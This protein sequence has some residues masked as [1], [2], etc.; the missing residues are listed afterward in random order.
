MPRFLPLFDAAQARALDR[1]A[2]AALGITEYDLMQRAA[3]A[4]WRQLLDRWPNAHRIGIAVGP[5]NNGG[6]GLVLARLARESGRT[7]VVVRLRDGESKAPT[8]REALAG[9][10][11]A[12]G[13]VAVFEGALP[14]VD[15]W[16]DALFGIGFARP[17]EGEV[18]E[19][20]ESINAAGTDVFALD[21][22]SGV[23]ADTGHVPGAAIRA[24]RTLTFLAGKCGLHT[25]AALDRV[26][27][28]EVDA[29]GLG[30]AFV[31]AHESVARLA[32][33]DALAAWLPARRHDSNKGDFGH[34]R[35]VGG[36]HGTAGAILL[37][38]EAA[39]RC[40][41]GLVSV[42]TRAENVPVVLARRPEVMAR[43]VEDEAAFETAL[44][45]ATV[46][47]VGPG[48]GKGDWGRAMLAAALRSEKPLVL[49]AD[50]LNLLSEYP[51]G[52]SGAVLT[53]HP[54]EAGRLLGIPTVQVQADRIGSARELAGRYDCCVVLKGAGTVVA[55]PRVR[56]VLIPAGNPGMASGGMGD[57][58]TGVIAA[59]R[60]QR[61]APFDAAVCGALL[62][63]LAGDAAAG[64]GGERG[65]IASDLF[66]HLHLLANPR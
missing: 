43:A 59:L 66:T 52:V 11:A 34:V 13:E 48:L 23:D 2:Q 65:L 64:D 22:P 17:P 1:D 32:G 53:P 45:G 39:L 47:A 60:A 56:P 44:D 20:I 29:L 42:A 37:A 14:A 16:V 28:L 30:E 61:L 40:G 7:A 46:L 33:R 25:G 12:G 8:A 24:T 57:V 27:R 38:S 49:D 63:A 31:A 35:C 26:G 50:A 3:A 10:T 21:V 6:D 58:L 36:D 15:L 4:A 18:R 54:G 19:L 41:A 9:W 55:A 51:R 62:H 5:G